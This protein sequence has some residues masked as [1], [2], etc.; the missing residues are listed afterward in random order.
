MN[1]LSAGCLTATPKRLLPVAGDRPQIINFCK[2]NR[3]F[4][5]TV[6]Y[7]TEEK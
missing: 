4:S 6:N 3:I 2:Y 1:H 5:Q 7:N